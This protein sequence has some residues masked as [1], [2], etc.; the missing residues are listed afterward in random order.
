[1][2]IHQYPVSAIAIAILL[3]TMLFSLPALALELGDAKTRGLVGETAS[4]YLAAVKP[5]AEVNALVNSINAQ[6]KA[7]YQKIADKNKIGL[8]AVEVRAGQK[9]ISKTP[10]GQYVNP[11]S[12]WQKK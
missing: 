7:Q 8:E 1:M 6:R 12:G 9:A 5:S 10:A 2:R 11:G 3:L 4:G